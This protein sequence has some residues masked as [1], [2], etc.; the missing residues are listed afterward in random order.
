MNPETMVAGQYVGL[1]LCFYEDGE[2]RK[3]FAIDPRNPASL[4]PISTG[5]EACYYDELQGA[6]YVF[7][8]VNVA[9]WD[10]GAEPMTALHRSKVFRQPRPSNAA[11]AEVVADDYP[12]QFRLWAGKFSSAGWSAGALKLTRNVTGRS[13][14]KLPGGYIAEDMQ[15]EVSGTGAIVAAV[16]AGSV[17]E[18]R[19]T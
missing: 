8:G 15:I 13:V 3:G 1:Y 12:V 17:D 5:F 14:F 18:I 19:E 10:A 16:A 2:T 11:V 4:Y 7:S 9:K 6:L